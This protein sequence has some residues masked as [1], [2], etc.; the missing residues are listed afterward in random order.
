MHRR[1]FLPP[2]LGRIAA[3]KKSDTEEQR[4]RFSEASITELKAISAKSSTIADRLVKAF[5]LESPEF[6]S[7]STTQLQQPKS[8]ESQL[9]AAKAAQARTIL[10]NSTEATELETKTQAIISNIVKPRYSI[11]EGSFDHSCLGPVAE[12]QFEALA[13]SANLSA[14]VV[15]ADN[16]D[17]VNASNKALA[18]ARLAHE[19]VINATNQMA[20]NMLDC[21]KKTDVI[22]EAKKEGRAACL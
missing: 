7:M 10:A 17:D 22:N 5:G 4:K 14:F 12:Q 19:A 9:E 11:A 18:N 21:S 8:I 1:P 20:K 6:K 3:V 13:Q 16:T 2:I 15:Q